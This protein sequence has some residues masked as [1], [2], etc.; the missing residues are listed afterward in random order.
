M[1]DNRKRPRI[2]SAFIRSLP[3]RGES[4]AD[5]AKR[6]GIS[7]P[8]CSVLMGKTAKGKNPRVYLGT[9]IDICK[10]LKISIE[11][12]LYYDNTALPAGN[13]FYES[14]RYGWF[15]DN[16]RISHSGDDTW[17]SEHIKLHHDPAITATNGRM[18]FSGTITNC[19]NVS[20]RI[21]A[22]RLSDYLF[23]M[24]SAS[25]D[26][27]R[28]FVGSANH[29]IRYEEDELDVLT[30]TWSG[31]DIAGDPAVFR[32]IL[33]NNKLTN[34]DI[35]MICDDVPVRCYGD[36]RNFNIDLGPEY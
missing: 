1:P 18:S 16:N 3:K 30:G 28:S 21:K 11:D 36:A 26:Q 25:N 20:F 7:K 24:A 34:T 17:F 6:L 22:E 2:N 32:W 5:F 19:N 33:T 8:Q 31:L 15:I 12:I 4:T 13:L 9:L 10:Q 35:E 14:I 29:Y 27:R 23:Y